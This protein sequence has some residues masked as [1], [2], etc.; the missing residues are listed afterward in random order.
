MTIKDTFEM[1]S[2]DSN[3]M[4]KIKENPIQEA[5]FFALSDF[6]KQGN[7]LSDIPWFSVTKYGR[8]HKNNV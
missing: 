5:I 4:K 3:I 7:N 1:M 8:R 2:H 6:V